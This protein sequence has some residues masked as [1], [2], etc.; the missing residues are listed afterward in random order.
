MSDDTQIDP[1]L[2]IN[3]PSLR[4]LQR[5]RDNPTNPPSSNPLSSDTEDAAELPPGP[6][7]PS[8][9]INSLSGFNCLVKRHKKLSAESEADFD[10]F[11]SVR[12]HVKCYSLV[13]L[14]FR[15]HPLRNVLAC[16]L[17]PL[18]KHATS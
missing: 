5:S 9:S 15:I 7:L 14:A 3:D 16:S 12:C 1:Q 6:S 8:V 13:D 4:F 18:F 10:D 11:C 2:L 17:L